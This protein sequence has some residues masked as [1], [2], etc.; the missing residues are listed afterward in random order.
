MG[1]L[2]RIACT[3]IMALTFFLV[4]SL[5]YA[6][7]GQ[8]LVDAV[9]DIKNEG[10]GNI[11]P[12]FENTIRDAAGHA[13]ANASVAID[14]AETAIVDAGDAASDVADNVANAGNPGEQDGNTTSTVLSLPER[15]DRMYDLNRVAVLNVVD[16]DTMDVVDI[17]EDPVLGTDVIC[18]NMYR[19]RLA[20]VDTPE[21]GERGYDSAKQYLHRTCPVGSIAQHDPDDG[22]SRGSYGR[23]V[24]LVWC[25]GTGA[26]SVNEMILSAQAGKL[27][28][29][30]CAVSEFNEDSWA[31]TYGC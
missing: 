25:E 5:A 31:R 23:I 7:I 2:K 17:C 27:L 10:M 4:V 1:F 6:F 16:G 24:S 22:Q 14:S 11:I 13:G 15:K 19:I 28:T 9:G 29:Q 21:Y 26:H 20:L 30:Y 3:I 18:G 8:D 12:W